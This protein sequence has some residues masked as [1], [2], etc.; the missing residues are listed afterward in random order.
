MITQ[1]KSFN[2]HSALSSY[3]S[4]VDTMTATL[5]VLRDDVQ[6]A[7]DGWRIIYAVDFAE[8]YEFAYKSLSSIVES[9]PEEQEEARFVR[10]CV[11]LEYIFSDK[12][13]KLILLPPYQ[14]E[15]ADHIKLAQGRLLDEMFDRVKKRQRQ[16]KGEVRTSLQGAILSEKI[17]EIARERGELH[18]FT[19]EE[20]RNMGQMAVDYFKDLSTW[21][22]L[23]EGIEGVE[24][25]ATLVKRGKVVTDTKIHRSVQS[26]RAEIT[27]RA[28]EIYV[29]LLERRGHKRSAPS[30]I[31]ALACAYIEHLN[32]QL[33]PQKEYLVL[34]SHSHHMKEV[35]LSESQRK[36]K[37]G[38]VQLPPY[39][40]DLDYFL[41]RLTHSSY[42]LPKDKNQAK[43][44]LD[45]IQESEKIFA[46]FH[47]IRDDVMKLERMPERSS[48]DAGRTVQDR[49][50]DLI[51]ILKPTLN[52]LENRAL[53]DNEESESLKEKARK[54]AVRVQDKESQVARLIFEWLYPK[55]MPVME[56]LQRADEKLKA[57][58]SETSRSLYQVFRLLSADLAPFRADISLDQDTE[59][60]LLTGMPGE[61]PLSLRFT[62]EGVQNLAVLLSYHHRNYDADAIEKLR[63]F[64]ID[65]A[66]QTGA[67][68]PG[69]HLLIAYV[70]CMTSDWEVALEELELGCTKLKSVDDQ[71]EFLFLRT[72]ILRKLSAWQQ[73]FDVCLEGI[74]GQG[75]R[76]DA[77][78]NR[79]MAVVIWKCLETHE[80]QEHVCKK[81]GK[82]PSIDLAI[83]YAKEAKTIVWK[84]SH[85]DHFLLGQICNTLA[86]LHAEKGS[87]A[88]LRMADDYL[89]ELARVIPET[90]W[91]NRFFDTQGYVRFKKSLKENDPREKRKL[92]QDALADFQKAV[93]RK[94]AGDWEQEIEEQHLREVQEALK[95]AS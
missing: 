11:A 83:Y 69:V 57:A 43:A 86:Y 71:R 61:P 30:H 80:N 17:R 55:G 92:L 50:L 41:A 53:I 75:E 20:H 14:L 65:L 39:V 42:H 28:Q 89:K 36:R 13:D 88:D 48:S 82:V 70:M 24:K 40:R 54:A 91:V 60:I 34:I 67:E 26:Y 56:S 51:K 85:N 35:I 33:N 32:T 1:E 58:L 27:K 47:H 90:Q 93:S 84:D 62:E 12:F 49:A 79:E 74:A 15:L 73:A 2:I 37:D 77:R 95:Q 5:G 29:P 52:S 25:L 9:L 81:L 66:A 31:D 45:S 64:L 68:S 3:R 8:L 44:V 22:A 23:N 19:D 38:E 4:I 16:L 7:Q 21:V 72:L 10:G 18:R 78:L 46:N 6:L 59:V 63:E 76:Q 87:N 94:S